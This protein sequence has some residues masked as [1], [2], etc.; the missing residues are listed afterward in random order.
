[1]GHA[2]ERGTAHYDGWT[3]YLMNTWYPELVSSLYPLQKK[4]WINELP[5]G[6]ATVMVP[7]EEEPFIVYV[8]RNPHGYFAVLASEMGDHELAEKMIAFSEK[9]KNPVWDDGCYYFEPQIERIYDDN[10]H[11]VFAGRVETMALTFAA[12]NLE[13]GNGLST[14]V[15]QPWGKKHFSEPYISKVKHPE[16]IV[17]QAWYD[18]KKDTLIV[19]VQPG[20]EYTGN[21]SFLVNQLDASKKYKVIK[22]G[23]AV[24]SFNKGKVE[25]GQGVK[26][27][28]RADKGTLKISTDISKKHTFLVQAVK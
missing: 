19:T 15:N 24:G 22:D 10:G 12:L 5:D 16:V 4:H 18:D 21:T 14:I 3:G 25:A 13:G 8:V 9:H 23:K 6:T 1:M 11:F 28:E 26:V 20:T 27:L 2:R 17:S 7:E